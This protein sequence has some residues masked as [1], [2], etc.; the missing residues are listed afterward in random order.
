MQIS[1]LFFGALK[2]LVGT[3]GEL[4]TLAEPVRLGDVLRHY[5]ERV[6]GFGDYAGSLAMAVNQEYAQA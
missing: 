4:L 1:V 6:P 3:S 5:D 2:E